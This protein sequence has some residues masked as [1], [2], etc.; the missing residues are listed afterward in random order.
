MATRADAAEVGALLDRFNTEFGEPS[1]GAIVLAQRVAEH[2]E[3]D[4]S[5]FCLAAPKDAGIAQLRFRAALFG[6]GPTCYL[7]ELYIAPERRGQGH[8][9]TLMDTAIGLARGR[10]ASWIEV[11]TA[12]S[13]SAA[14]GLYE[15][16]GFSNFERE[17][18]PES[19]MLFYE[20]EL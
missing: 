6:D 5:V 4:W 16:L 18:D 17:H 20:R 2:I 12:V 14:R 7:E 9:R 8:G 19:Q 1:P 13:D 10:G 15:S 3:H 11:G